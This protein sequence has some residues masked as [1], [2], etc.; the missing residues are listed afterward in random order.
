MFSCM[1]M[2]YYFIMYVRGVLSPTK[3]ISISLLIQY[4]LVCTCCYTWVG[5]TCPCDCGS[6]DNTEHDSENSIHVN[7]IWLASQPALTSDWVRRVC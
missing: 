4:I 7:I 2:V 3:S 1:Q 5:A 6:L